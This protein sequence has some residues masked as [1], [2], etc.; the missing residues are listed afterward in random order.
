MK[1]TEKLVIFC[2]GV[3]VLVILK[4][5]EQEYLFKYGNSDENYQ[6]VFSE[7]ILFDTPAGFSAE[8][9]DILYPTRSDY[10][11]SVK[12]GL[13]GRGIPEEIMKLCEKEAKRRGFELY[14]KDT[15]LFDPYRPYRLDRIVL[16]F[17]KMPVRLTVAI[18]PNRF[19]GNSD[20]Q[21][22]FELGFRI[23]RKHDK[24]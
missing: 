15:A 21:I 8:G 22:R 5:F 11:I 18:V 14:E 6:A 10:Y 2:F 19:P 17:I 24:K 20:G 4:G 13:E 16:R 12:K 3:V 9:F 23:V 7:Y 1:F